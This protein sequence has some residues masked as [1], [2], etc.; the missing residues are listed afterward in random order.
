M[1]FNTVTSRGDAQA[2]IPEDVADGI[3]QGAVKQSAA[4]NLF[5]RVS[6]SR[7]QQRMPVLSALPMAYFVNGDTGLKQTTKM[8]WENK[9]LNAEPIAVIVPIPE[10]VLDDSEF[11]MWGEIRP[12]LEEAIGR[13][14]DAAV[15]FGTDK[16]A[17]WPEAIVKAAD[18]A[19]GVYNLGTSTQAQGGIAED[20]NQLFGRV[21]EDGYE[22][23]GV[24]ARTGMRMRLRGA[25][26][27]TGQSLVDVQNG[28]VH[29]AALR[30]LMQ[31]MWPNASTATPTGGTVTNGYHALVGDFSQGIMAVRKDLS[32]KVLTESVITDSTGAV[33]LNLAQQDAVAL[34]VVGRF[35]FQ[36]A[37]PINY[38]N[39]NA[40]TR[41]P[42]AAL[43]TPGT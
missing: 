36:V 17:S 19:G 34:R 21:E 3:L 15:F 25:R 41:Y 16:P 32:Y 27:T 22:V 10:D 18:A 13:A 9:F 2:L 20:F 28:Q 26:D 30:Y 23:N 39:P 7:K 42:F 31:G 1:P 14:L 4:L 38:D 24:V 8:A 29:G 37:N 33:V 12:R 40:A 43:R 5:R 11:D 35:A 6:M